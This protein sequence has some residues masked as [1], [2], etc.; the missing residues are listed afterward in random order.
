[1][2]YDFAITVPAG[3]AEND[4]VVETLKLTKGII[5]RVEVQFPPGCKGYVYLVLMHEGHQLFPE[6]REGAF[7]TSG[8][9]IPIDEHYP[10]KSR[11]FNLKAVAWAP[12]ASHDHTITVR[13]GIL[14]ETVMSPLTELGVNL[15]RFFKLMGVGG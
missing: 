7:Q 4:P 13:I 12:D 8:H 6:N 2:Y 5:H 11:P 3:T 9:T 15:K 1:M 10:L 14:P